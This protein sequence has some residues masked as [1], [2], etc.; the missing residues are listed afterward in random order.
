MSFIYQNIIYK[1]L[2]NGL[3]FLYNTVSFED[4]G[5]A[6]VLLTLIIRLIL[7]P[8]FHKSAE[9]QKKVQRIQPKIKSIQEKHKHNKDK[10]LQTQEILSIYKEEGLNPFSGF[11]LILVQLPIL[12]ALYHIF[13][14][15]FT[16]EIFNGLYSFVARP[17]TLNAEFLGLINLAE[18]SILMVVLAAIFQ[19]LQGKLA[20]PKHKSTTD[21]VT[22]RMGRQM[23]FLGPVLTV[24]IF[25]NFP[26]A[27]ALYWAVASLFSVFQQMIIN[28]KLDHGKVE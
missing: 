25:Y 13:L 11:F 28:K 21:S 23:V 1:P 3:V 16:P 14:K 9:Y 12:F 19:Y 8:L 22:E 20:L 4:L 24:V 15:I 18:S 17:E 10:A 7:F 27:I 26:A 6:I 5:I 2:L